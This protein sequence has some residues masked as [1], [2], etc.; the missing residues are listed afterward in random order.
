LF[1]AVVA[2]GAPRRLNADRKRAIADDS[3]SPD[4]FVELV[5]RNDSIAMIEEVTQ[6]LHN[7]RLDWDAPVVA[8]EL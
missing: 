6:K 7:L 5:T 1:C 2:D 8:L 4:G 3:A